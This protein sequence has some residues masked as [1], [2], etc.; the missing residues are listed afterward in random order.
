MKIV[1]MTHR[2]WARKEHSA[3]ITNDFYKREVLWELRVDYTQHEEGSQEGLPGG[4]GLL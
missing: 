1:K 2:I 4:R 3:N